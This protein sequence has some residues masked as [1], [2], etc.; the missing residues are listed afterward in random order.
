MI[1]RKSYFHL[2][3]IIIN[4]SIAY[5]SSSLSNNPNSLDELKKWGEGVVTIQMTETENAEFRVV[6]AESNKE[7]RQGLMHIDFMEENEGMLFIF[8]PPRKVSMW[9]RNT[10]MILDMIFI[11]EDEE[12]I[13][14][15]KE[16][17]PY[18][19]K[20][21]PSGGSIKW[22]LEISGG[23]SERFNIKTGDRVKL[24]T[25]KGLVEE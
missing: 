10:P 5:S 17:T 25:I 22:V 1:T 19:T 14:I 8:N 15:E 23:L 12:I 11:N 4:L 24:T 7:R 18:S 21:V 16:T 2:F 6:I 13:T 3:V 20:G 9:M